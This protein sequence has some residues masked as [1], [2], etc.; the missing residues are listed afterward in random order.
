MIALID[1]GAGN[2]QSV[3][4]ALKVAGAADLAITADPDAVAKADRIVLPG[5]GA[6]AACMN[7]LT[8]IPGMVEAMRS[9]VLNGGVPFLGVCVGMQLLATTGEEFGSH[10]GLG[11]IEGTVR[12]LTPAPGVTV[13]HM[14]WNDVVPVR[15]HPLLVPGEAYFLHSYAFEGEDVLA[16]TDHGG[17][18]T[19]AI[20]RDNILGAQFHPEKSQ[21]YGLALL[22]RFLEWRP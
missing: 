3:A 9:R 1:Y 7:G 20:G 13:P 22:E 21:R 18:V 2:L 4:N 14:G 6:F 12:R 17:P 15:E 10:A 5:V 19:A 8:A 11:W 16:T